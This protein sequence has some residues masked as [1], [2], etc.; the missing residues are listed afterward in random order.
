MYTWA[1]KIGLV[2]DGKQAA[3]FVDALRQT[4]IG[5]E[6]EIYGQLVTKFGKDPKLT[7]IP[8][9]HLTTHVITLPPSR[10][11]THDANEQICTGDASR[12]RSGRTDYYCNLHV[13]GKVLRVVMHIW[14]ASAE[15]ARR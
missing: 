15:Q 12:K 9:F 11:F 13:S 14:T 2:N 10:T 4:G 6:L 5:G 1:A 7:R 3:I 8:A